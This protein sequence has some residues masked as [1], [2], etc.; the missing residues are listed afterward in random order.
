[1]TLNP[2]QFKEHLALRQQLGAIIGEN[3]RLFPLPEHLK[4]L[5]AKNGSLFGPNHPHGAIPADDLEARNARLRMKIES[6]T[7]SNGTAGDQGSQ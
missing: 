4:A 5:N 2:N 1:M 7:I 3:R 6:T